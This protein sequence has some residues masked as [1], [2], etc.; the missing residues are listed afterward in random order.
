[1]TRKRCSEWSKARV[2][3][4]SFDH[5]V[6]Q[7]VHSCFTAWS[8]KYERSHRQDEK[9]V[10]GRN[11]VLVWVGGGDFICERTVHIWHFFG[12]GHSRIHLYC[13]VWFEMR[14][15]PKIPTKINNQI[16]IF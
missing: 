11:G 1:L 14:K 5:V 4:G 12:V 7:M 10:E 16:D 3:R 15:I 6:R 13:T 9:G 8:V 2:D